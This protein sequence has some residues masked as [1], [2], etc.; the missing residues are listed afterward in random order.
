MNLLQKK[1]KGYIAELAIA[2]KLIQN[3]WRVLIPYG[4]NQ[5]YDLVAEKNNK[6]IRIQ[7][8][9]CTPKNGVLNVNC[10]SSN[11]WS[12]LHYTSKE[13]D[14]IA[15]YN[16]KGEEVYFIPVSKINHSLFKIR[17]EPTKNKQKLK[18]HSA[19]D[20]EGLKV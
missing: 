17:I 8:K 10:R 3:G 19:N 11:N 1:A 12:V 4:E 15:V 13:I 9:Y 2:A 16:P 18:I 20:F 14:L 5:Q 7:A 6:F